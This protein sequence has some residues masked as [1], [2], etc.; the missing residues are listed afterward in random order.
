MPIFKDVK[1]ASR[2]E[3]TY[4]KLSSLEP[5]QFIDGIFLKRIKNQQYDQWV[6]KIF[7]SKHE[8]IGLNGNY[9]LDAYMDV[10]QPDSWVRITYL[11]PKTLKDGRTLQECQVQEANED[12]EVIALRQLAHLQ[13]KRQEEPK[14]P[15]TTLDDIMTNQRIPF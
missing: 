13:D 6:Y 12:A 9:Q 8:M 11:G 10:I 7:T 3:L 15:Q 2:G 5:G 1:P 14:Q 4:K